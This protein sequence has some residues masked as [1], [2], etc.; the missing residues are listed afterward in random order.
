MKRLLFRFLGILALLALIELA[1]GWLVRN[2]RGRDMVRRFNKSILNPWMLRHAGHGKWYASVVET[3][4]RKTGATYQTP[5]VADPV[6]DGFVIPLPYGEDVDWLKSAK[7]TGHATILRQ[8]LRYPV[9]R[10]E[11]LTAVEAAPV[12]TASRRLSYR[13]TGVDRFLRVHLEDSD[14]H[15]TV[16]G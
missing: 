13:M 3:T 9:D 8:D 5:V 4:G 12:L 16:G 10:F 6:V 15:L 2:E 11:E 14:G 1:F 7:A